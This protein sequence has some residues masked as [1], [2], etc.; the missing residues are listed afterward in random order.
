MNGRI[1]RGIGGFYYVRTDESDGA[2]AEWKNSQKDGN[3]RN[4][5]GSVKIYE[6]KARGIFRKEKFRPLPGDYVELEV[7]D[8]AEQE[9]NI[10]RI[11]PRKNALIRPAVAN[12]DQALI[13]MAAASPQ[14]NLN[15]MDRFL[16]MMEQ[17]GV[18]CR[19]CF[20]K[21]D[22]A[23][24]V[25]LEAL[26]ATYE[27]SGYPLYFTSA[28]RQEGVEALRQLLE[29]KT[30][31]VAGPSGVGKSSLINLLQDEVSM[32]TGEISRKIERGRHTTRHSELI[33]I[34]PGTEIV[35]TPGFSSIELMGM[36]KEELGSFF[37]EIARLEKECRFVGCAHRSEPGCRVKE[38][39]EEGLV[40]TGRYANYCQMYEELKNRR[41]Y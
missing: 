13:I 27:P 39:L 17:Q 2:A 24:E 21:K 8:E 9:G 20:K 15:L 18:P 5:A 37:P 38:G 19:I 31:V 1:I 16:V 3:T 7:L 6:C 28:A 25:A 23:E 41:K 33:R 36:E 35:D 26:R 30:T 29:G 10:G 40:S 14:P 22:L 34:R 32:Q 12:V 4:G 11:L